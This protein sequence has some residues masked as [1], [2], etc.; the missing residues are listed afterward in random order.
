MCTA[1]RSRLSYIMTCIQV[2]GHHTLLCTICEDGS[3]SSAIK[4]M[5]AAVAESTQLQKGGGAC[6]CK[7]HKT[8]WHP[9][10]L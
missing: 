5:R 1:P 2:G 8:T 10:L 6:W 7:V 3:C 4:V 9:R